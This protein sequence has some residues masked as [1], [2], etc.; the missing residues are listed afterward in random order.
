M[1]AHFVPVALSQMLCKFWYAFLFNE[2]VCFFP[3]RLFDA[4]ALFDVDKNVMMEFIR[5]K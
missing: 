1:R 2:C 3:F 5:K 4:H